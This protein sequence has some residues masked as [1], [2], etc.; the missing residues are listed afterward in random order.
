MS[1]ALDAH[2]NASGVN[3]LMELIPPVE[4]SRNMLKWRKERALTTRRG[5]HH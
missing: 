1:P 5:V 4:G 2:R 3:N